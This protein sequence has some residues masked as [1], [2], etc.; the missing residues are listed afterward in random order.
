LNN[1]V[2][3]I[4]QTLG[5]SRSTTLLSRQDSVIVN[6]L[7]IGHTRLATVTYY[8]VKYNQ[9]VSHASVL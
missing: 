3:A 7:K 5:D 9:N 4:K 6:R 2:Q 8:H 1:E